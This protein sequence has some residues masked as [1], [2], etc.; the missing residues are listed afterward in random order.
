MT[1][2]APVERLATNTRPRRLGEWSGLDPA[3]LLE[4]QQHVLELVA[5]GAPLVQTLTAIAQFSEAVIPGMLAS[6]LI[7]DPE[8]DALRKGGFGRLPASF[9]DAVDG[10]KPGPGMGSCGT[11]A[12]RRE[13]VVSVD[14]RIDPLWDALRSFA[15]EHGIVS[16]WSTPLLDARGELLGVFGMYHGVAREP[17][18][19]ELAMADHFSSLASIAIERHMAD[20][21]RER[22]ATSDVLTGLANRQ[23][24][25]DVAAAMKGDPAW[26]GRVCTLIML[27]CDHF[28]LHNDTLGQ[29]ASDRLLRLAA[30]RIRERLGAVPLLA[31]FEGDQFVA[32]LDDRNGAA[33]RRAEGLLRGFAEP[34]MLDDAPVSLTL[35]GGIVEWEPASTS[36]DDAIFQAVEAVEVAKR[37]G[38]DRV[39]VFGDSERA[40]LSGRRE[41]ARVLREALD[42]DRVQ[43]WL[44][45]IVRLSNFEPVGF[46]VLA[47]LRGPQAS[48]ISP[49][50]FVP[51]AEESSLI[52]R[53]G[54][55]VLRFSM[56]TLAEHGARMG[57]LTLSVNVSTRQLM[58][59]GLAD[60]AAAMA[61]EHGVDPF[62]VILEITESHWLDVDGPAR[63]NIEA[64][65]QHGFRLALDDFGVG[66]A[67]LKRLQRIPF[68][69]LKIDRSFTGELLRGSR[70]R[71][72]CEAALA[73]A[74][75]CEIPVTAEGVE[76]P[77]QAELLRELGYGFGQGYLWA[78]PMPVEQAMAWLDR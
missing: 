55:S 11:A 31:R 70:G 43:P 61:R 45:P 59:E 32:I 10:M 6:I 12:F 48:G 34:I 78:R 54:L 44:Q 68:D 56:R 17:L 41:V 62:R 63:S 15:A 5:G 25:Q 7:H 50:V 52:D 71:A 74:K 57:R 13:R 42:E 36:L 60:Q 58:R 18:A 19:E 51:I 53:L 24:L 35:S 14:V 1:R 40:Q 49:T 26:S 28:K 23:R 33:Q 69:H 8:Q 3:L 75:A 20:M 47:R 65:R 64:F 46:E 38:R 39:V 72:V 67:S 4:G 73:M 76:Q 66:Y 21:S 9:G 29:L 22:Q 37:L 2:A 77:D 27:D 16:A 30:Q